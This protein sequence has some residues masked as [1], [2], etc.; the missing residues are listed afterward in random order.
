MRKQI[1]CLTMLFVLALFGNVQAEILKIQPAKGAIALSTVSALSVNNNKIVDSE[2]RQK[3]LKGI[4]IVDP[5]ILYKNRP[6]MTFEKV[7]DL[8][9]SNYPDINTIRIMILP[10]PNQGE[11]TQGYFANSSSYLQSYLIPAVNLAIDKGFY[12]ILDLHYILDYSNDLKENKLIP[13][14]THIASLYKNTAN[15]I[16]EIMNEPIYPDD[17]N[18]WVDTVAQPVT[19]A[20]RAIADN[21][22]IVGGPRWNQNIAGSVLRPVNGINIAYAAHVYPQHSTSWENN[23]GSVAVKYP[24]LITEW[25]YKPGGAMPTNGTTSSFGQPF[26]DWMFSRSLSWVVFAFDSRWEPEMFVETP[27]GWVENSIDVNK[28]IKSYTPPATHYALTQCKT[29]P[30]YFTGYTSYCLNNIDTTTRKIT[31]ALECLGVTYQP[32]LPLKR[33]RLTFDLRSSASS[34]YNG[35]MLGTALGSI[36]GPIINSTPT[37]GCY[38]NTTYADVMLNFETPTDINNLYFYASTGDWCSSY[39]IRGM[40]LQYMYPLKIEDAAQYYSNLSEALA[41]M[42]DNSNVNLL[43]QAVRLSGDFNLDRPVNLTIKGGFDADFISLIGVTAIK[44]VLTIGQGS[45]TVGNV[46]IE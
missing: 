15:V 17:W 27:T 37:Y 4:A 34:C 5:E 23:F 41:D 12:V 43:S 45:L 8:A 20:I 33:I 1:V 40:E 31:E 3:I 13:F 46:A 21:I 19:D 9:K 7:L 22:V 39:N 25:G 36:D 14:W 11:G 42:P 28:I 44:G 38:E 26:M 35:T 29:N 16:F 18:Q 30:Q 10:D 6:D 24:L 32:G 2:G